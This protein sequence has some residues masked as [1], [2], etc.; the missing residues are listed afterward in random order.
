MQRPDAHGRSL[1]HV[2]RHVDAPLASGRSQSAHVPSQGAPGAGWHASERAAF[3][4]QLPEAHSRSSPH[5][6][7][8][9]N[10][11][12]HTQAWVEVHGVEAP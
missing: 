12:A 8:F 2:R 3:S 5:G 11:G 7:P 6:I 1:A 4:P 10:G 9:A